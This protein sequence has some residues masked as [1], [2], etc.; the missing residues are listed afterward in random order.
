MAFYVYGRERTGR[1]E[2]LAG[3]AA[4]ATFLIHSGYEEGFFVLRIE[5]YHPDGPRRASA[6]TVA[7]TYSVSIDYAV[8]KINHGVAYLC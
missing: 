5:F 1:A 3:S 4:Y 7:A 8:V 6:C 2:V